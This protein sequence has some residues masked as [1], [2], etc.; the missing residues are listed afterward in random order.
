MKNS[1]IFV[2]THGYGDILHSRQGVRW[3]V[4]SLGDQFNYFFMHVKDKDTCFI[5]EKVD[6]ISLPNNLYACSVDQLKKYITSPIFGNSLW[7]DV[8]AASFKNES[9]SRYWSQVAR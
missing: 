4:E 1:I 9:N 3:V 2:N 5:H 8:W 7:V 6:V